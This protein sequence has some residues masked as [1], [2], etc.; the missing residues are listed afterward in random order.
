[1]GVFKTIKHLYT[2]RVFPSNPHHIASS[3]NFSSTMSRKEG[4]HRD[5][6]INHIGTHEASHKSYIEWTRPRLG[7]G[8]P[9]RGNSHLIIKI[10][11]LISD[12]I[13]PHWDTQCPSGR[14]I[15][16]K[17]Y[18]YPYILDPYRAT[19]CI[20]IGT[21]FHISMT[22]PLGPQRGPYT[23]DFKWYRVVY[24]NPQSLTSLLR[25]ETV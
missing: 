12:Y 15:F 18:R 2:K 6:C 19:T 24:N 21:L 23:I 14:H 13:T 11:I 17:E 5:P 25:G 10:Q 22:D 1:M 7:A 9:I 4:T 16:S 3:H 20:N 8:D